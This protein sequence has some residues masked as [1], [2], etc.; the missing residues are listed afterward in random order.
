MPRLL[1]FLIQALLLFAILV[2]LGILEQIY[3]VI[4]TEF[5][6]CTSEHTV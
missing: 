4:K 3:D 6:R 1:Q 2:S 5:C